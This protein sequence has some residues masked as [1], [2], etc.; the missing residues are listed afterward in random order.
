MKRVTVYKQTHD[1]WHPPYKLQGCTDIKLVRVLFTQ[2]G[3]NPDAGEG[4]WRVCVWGGDDCGM[5]H[6]YNDKSQALA[7]FNKIIQ[8]EIVDIDNLQNHGFVS[9]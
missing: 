7:M 1:D 6:D 4:E 3:R 5:E 8:W 9:A 2:T